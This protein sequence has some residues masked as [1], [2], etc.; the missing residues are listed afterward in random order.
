MKTLMEIK[1]K[2]LVLLE[3]RASDWRQIWT[4]AS[5]LDIKG[6][7]KQSKR[8]LFFSLT[9]HFP[10]IVYGHIYIYIIYICDRI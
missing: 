2:K 9:G 6:N 7:M 10:R 3:D 4:A 5:S 8:I 1:Q